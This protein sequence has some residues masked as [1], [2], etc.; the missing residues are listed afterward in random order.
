MRKKKGLSQES[1][2]AM[3]NLPGNTLNQKKPR[4]VFWRAKGSCS[5]TVITDSDFYKNLANE[6][7]E[8]MGSQKEEGSYLEKTLV[9]QGIR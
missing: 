1:T 4:L 8:K 3:N 9:S 6:N 5:G 7:Q 2:P